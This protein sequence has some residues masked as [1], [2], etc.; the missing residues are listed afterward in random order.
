MYEGGGRICQSCDGVLTV[1][2][3]LG[4]VRRGTAFEVEEE[5]GSG[6]NLPT[7]QQRGKVG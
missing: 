7:R 5:I 6:G 3:V 1:S 2:W 4:F